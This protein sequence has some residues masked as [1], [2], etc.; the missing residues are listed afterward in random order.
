MTDSP[1][2]PAATHAT[3]SLAGRMVNVLVAPGETWEAVRTEGYRASNWVVPLLMGM[4]AGIVFIWGAFSQP[5]VVDEIMEQQGKAFD[6]LVAER[7][8]TADQADKAR[9]QMDFMRPT[10]VA[11][12]R[13]A[14]SAGLAVMAVGMQFLIALLVSLIAR[15]GL[16]AALPYR[17]CMEVTG[18]A[19]VIPALGMLVTLFLVV[20][21]GSMTANLGPILLVSNGAVGGPLQAV[22]SALNLFNLWWCA[23]LSGGTARLAGRSWGAAAAWVFGLYALITAGAAGIAALNS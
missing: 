6:K 3:T 19:G 23:A 20:I 2:V 16:G 9:E 7:R 22:L 5:G 13:L 15:W 18:L 4:I 8:M 21:K 14:G 1:P 12:G 17:K 10:I 11:I